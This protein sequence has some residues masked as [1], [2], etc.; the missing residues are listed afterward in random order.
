[1]PEGGAREDGRR[2]PAVSELPTE[3]AVQPA[4]ARASARRGRDRVRSRGRAR[5]PAERRAGCG[6]VRVHQNRGFPELRRADENQGVAGGA[7]RRVGPPCPLLHVRRDALVAL[8]SPADLRPSGRAGLRG[9]ARHS[10]PR[11]A[12]TSD[13]RRSE[14]PRRPALPLRHACRLSRRGRIRPSMSFNSVGVED[15]RRSRFIR[16]QQWQKT[17]ES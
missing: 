13:V 10:P 2:C 12:R 1:M 15:P 16:G 9:G 4:G 8:P 17:F 7:R 11:A 3:P 14:R 5:W 6:A